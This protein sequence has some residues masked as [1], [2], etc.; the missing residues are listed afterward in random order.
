VCVCVCVGVLECG[1]HGSRGCSLRCGC[2]SV[3]SLS[4]PAIPSGSQL[5]SRGLHLTFQRVRS[6]WRGGGGGGGGRDKGLSLVA[7]V[8]VFVVTAEGGEASQ[9]DSKREENLS[10]C[11]H[12]Y[13]ENETGSFHRGQSNV[14]GPM[15]VLIIPQYLKMYAVKLHLCVVCFCTCGS[16]RRVW[17]GLR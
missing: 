3:F 13:L 15:A 8:V 1:K 10:A 5:T 6:V 4:I 14:R 9:T 12:P 17:L 11:I 7:V 2:I 16:A